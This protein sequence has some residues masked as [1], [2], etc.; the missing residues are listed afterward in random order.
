M[1]K[2]H[3][4]DSNVV[5]SLNKS[6]YTSDSFIIFI[7]FSIAVLASRLQPHVLRSAGRKLSAVGV[8]AET[9][10]DAVPVL[11]DIRLGQP[12]SSRASAG[13]RKQL[14]IMYISSRASGTEEE[15][16]AY[17]GTGVTFSATSTR[18]KVSNS[19]AIPC[20]MVNALVGRLSSSRVYWRRAMKPQLELKAWASTIIHVRCVKR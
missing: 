16:G 1:R 11:R 3:C 10:P 2:T 8:L 19:K 5:V 17:P 12:R 15:P 4:N 7:P 9:Q 18:L 13:K 14:N 20:V 6:I